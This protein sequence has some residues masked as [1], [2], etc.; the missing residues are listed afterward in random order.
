[1]KILRRKVDDPWEEAAGQV[2]T[3]Y[4]WFKA[5]AGLLWLPEPQVTMHASLKTFADAFEQ[6]GL[7]SLIDE[8]KGIGVSSADSS[9]YIMIDSICYGVEDDGVRKLSAVYL[10]AYGKLICVG[11]LSGV[12]LHE[13]A[14]AAYGVVRKVGKCEGLEMSRNAGEFVGGLAQAEITGRLHDYNAN[15]TVKPG[16][17]KAEVFFNGR[18]AGVVEGLALDRLLEE[19][20]EVVRGQKAMQMSWQQDKVPERYSHADDL[21]KDFLNGGKRRPLMRP[22]LRFLAEERYEAGLSIQQLFGQFEASPSY[23]MQDQQEHQ[24]SLFSRLLRPFIG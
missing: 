2:V 20:L 5:Q 22:F 10:Q 17:G 4:G 24:P 1:M 8:L 12:F 23:R 21:A 3:G 13:G 11:A 14:E 18:K 16:N 15:V 6:S 9:N 7:E 19:S